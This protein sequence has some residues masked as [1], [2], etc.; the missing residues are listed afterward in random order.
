[1]YAKNLTVFLVAC[2]MGIKKLKKKIKKTKKLKTQGG[3]ASQ[4]YHNLV[5]QGVVFERQGHIPEAISFYRQALMINDADGNLCAR[6]AYVFFNKN[7]FEEAE[8]YLRKG[9]AIEP[10][11][12][13]MTY[14]LAKVLE[15]MGQRKAAENYYR[16]VIA[17]NPGNPKNYYHLGCMFEEMGRVSDAKEL[18]QK[19]LEVQPEYSYAHRH[20]AFLQ[21]YEKPDE[22]VAL[23]EKIYAANNFIEDQKS[24]MGLALSKV[25]EDL[26][27]YDK[28]FSFMEEANS[29]Q[30]ETYLYDVGQDTALFENLAHCFTAQYFER[31]SKAG[32]TEKRP[33]FIV[34]MLRTGTSLVEQI[35]AS[36]PEV[37]GAGELEF[38]QN[39]IQSRGGSI[40]SK[41]FVDNNIINKSLGEFAE[42]GREYVEKV[43]KITGLGASV[44]VVDKMPGNFRFVGLIKLMLPKARIVHCRRNPMDTCLSI[45]KN[46]FEGHHP[47]G[48][49]LKELG[50][51]Y[52]QYDALMAHWH[53]VLPG[54]IYDIN[55]EDILEDQEGQS[56][57]LL[58][59]CGLEWDS[60]CLAFHKTKRTVATASSQQVRKP[61]YKDSLNLWEKYGANLDPLKAALGDLV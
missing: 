58:E 39:V 23:M 20:L 10:T 7:D 46:F 14:Y 21:K 2:D 34:G 55:Y 8:I 38:I 22:H 54:F 28:A 6:L 3:Q 12:E 15:K 11:S 47:Y 49:K 53:K 32:F 19:T 9:L 26:Q 29:L 27:S 51:Y 30:R 45:Y 44:S 40:Y 18:Y 50:E 16:K 37:F 42:M 5:Q 57:L 59:F 31:M 36:H 24:Y 4:A 61:I 48:Y 41:G 56:R 13:P 35:L 60:Q 33:I 25:Y 1:M 17:L 43:N 52:R